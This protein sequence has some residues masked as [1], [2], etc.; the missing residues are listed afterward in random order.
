VR[1]DAARLRLRPPLDQ[2]LRHHHRGG[3]RPEHPEPQQR[4]ARK[5]HAEDVAQRQ[6]EGAHLGEGE[7][8]ERQQRRHAP[9][10]LP[11][12]EAADR[13]EVRLVHGLQ[14][15]RRGP[16]C[17]PIGCHVHAPPPFRPM[18]L[19]GGSTASPCRIRKCRHRGPVAIIHGGDERVGRLGLVGIDCPRPPP[20]YPRGST[21]CRLPCAL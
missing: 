6:I 10:E 18:M 5:V 13:I 16:S 9:E 2:E 15:G 14:S 4:I 20:P 11:G 1:A 21:P 19:S 7:N 3:Q 8:A 17:C 12:Q